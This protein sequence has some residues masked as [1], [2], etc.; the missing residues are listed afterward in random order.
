MRIGANVA[1][2]Q[3][4]AVT[5]LVE[6]APFVRAVARAGYAAVRDTSTSTTWTRTFARRS[7]RVP[8]RSCS[9]G[10][11]RGR[12]TRQQY[13]GDERGA[14][15]SI[16]GDPEPNLL[17]DVDGDRVGRAMPRKLMELSG[18]M[19]L[20]E[21]LINWTGVAFP[22]AGWAETIF[23]EPDV[24]RLWELLAFTVRLDEPDPVAAWREHLDRLDRAGS[25]A[26]RAAL[27]R[28]ALS[29]RRDRP[30]DRP[31]A[32]RELRGG[33]L[34]HLVG[35]RARAEHAHRGGLRRA[36]TFAAPRASFARRD[37]SL[38]W[39]SW[40]KGSSCASRAGRSST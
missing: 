5:A 3:I 37:R 24:E 6:H 30:D 15:V 18:R 21:Q 11:R 35:A 40:S 14:E 16:S 38:C 23:G 20:D 32:G 39:A 9:S 25:R 28:A 7:S 4:L 19:M 1:P 31:L 34:P 29:R 33:P 8:P 36:R 26:Q 22:N 10:A 17:A 12:S 27:R 13:L 2:G